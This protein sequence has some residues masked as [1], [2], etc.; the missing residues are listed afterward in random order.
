MFETWKLF[1]GWFL[2]SLWLLSERHPFVQKSNSSKFKDLVSTGSLFLDIVNCI[3]FWNKTIL[4][5]FIKETHSRRFK[6]FAGFIILVFFIFVD[7]KLF[8][9]INTLIVII[10]PFMIISVILSFDPLFLLPII[11]DDLKYGTLLL[12]R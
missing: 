1:C 3:L 2:T 8:P 7:L 4:K 10:S 5:N 11:L 12:F 9:N 6:Y